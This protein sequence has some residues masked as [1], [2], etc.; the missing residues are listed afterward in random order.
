MPR[1]R[2]TLQEREEIS[3]GISRDISMRQS[4]R[5]PTGPGPGDVGVER[6]GHYGRPRIA[7]MVSI[8]ER[9]AE[10]ANRKVPGH[11]EGNLM[12]GK[13]AHSAVGTLRNER[14]DSRYWP[15]VHLDQILKAVRPQTP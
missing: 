5:S 2:L 6:R 3:L 14:R 11:W 12:I 7:D 13:G 4:A 8:D 1:R 10:V 15:R 9:P